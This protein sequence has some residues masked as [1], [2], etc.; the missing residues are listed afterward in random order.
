VRPGIVPAAVLRRFE[1]EYEF[2]GR[3]HHP[4]IAQ[5]FTSRP[6]SCHGRDRPRP[7][8]PAPSAPMISYGPTLVPIVRLILT[9]RAKWRKSPPR[10][11]ASADP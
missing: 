10:Q 9:P 11:H 8:P 2:L 1:L 5:I 7:M 6:S 3:L 4:G